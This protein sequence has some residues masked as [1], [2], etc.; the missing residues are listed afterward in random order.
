MGCEIR[1]KNGKVIGHLADSMDEEDYLIVD[2]KKIPLSD[3]MNSTDLKDSFN[4]DIKEQNKD[5]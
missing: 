3:V 4:N 1:T 5:D 2:N